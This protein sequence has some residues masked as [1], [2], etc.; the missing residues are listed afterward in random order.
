M[1]ESSVAAEALYRCGA[2]CV[3]HGPNQETGTDLHKA[4]RDPVARLISLSP[5]DRWIVAAIDSGNSGRSQIVADY[6]MGEGLPRVLCRVCAVGSWEIDPPIVSWSLDQKSMYISLTALIALG[7][8]D[9]TRVF[10][11]I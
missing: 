6:P 1:A 8:T 9:Y 4:I 2:R 11:S 3:H 10:L 5:D 7:G